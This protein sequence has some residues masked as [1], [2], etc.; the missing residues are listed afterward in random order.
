M[1]TIVVAS[2]TPVRPKT[3]PP[4]QTINYAEGADVGHRWFAR[5]GLKPLFPFGHDL[6]YSGFSHSNLRLHGGR[7]ISAT[8]DVTNIGSVEGQYVPQLYLTATPDKSLRRLL[9]FEKVHLAPSETRQ[10]TMKIDP[11]LLA[12]YSEIQNAWLIAGG[13]YRISLGKSADELQ[14]SEKVQVDS[15]VLRP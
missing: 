4:F 7:S 13:A 3:G 5:E 14:P 15:S 12:N 6:S 9:G 8:F 10:V 11:R 1:A 2:S